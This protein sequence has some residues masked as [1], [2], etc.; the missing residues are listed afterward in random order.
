MK[1]LVIMLVPLALVTL[2]PPATG[3]DIQ[4]KH[5]FVSSPNRN[6]GASVSALNIERG[7]DYPSVIRL[8]GSVEIKLPVCIRTRPEN[9]LVCN[10]YLMVRADSAEMHEESGAIEAHGDVSIRPTNF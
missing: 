6:M 3:Q 7:V 2:L 9:P 1:R 4:L 10:G 8:R 5:L